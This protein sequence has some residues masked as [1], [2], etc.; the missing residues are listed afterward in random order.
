ML[1]YWQLTRGNCQLSPHARIG[2]RFT[3]PHPLGVVIGIG[4][5]IGNDVSIWQQVTLGNDGTV[6]S[7]PTVEDGVRIYAGSVVIGRIRLG[8][9]ALSCTVPGQQGRSPLERSRS[10]HPHAS[11]AIPHSPF[12]SCR[13]NKGVLLMSNAQNETPSANLWLANSKSICGILLRLQRQVECSSRIQLPK[14]SDDHRYFRCLFTNNCGRLS[15][16]V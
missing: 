12:Q 1:S 15:S 6:E 7:Y 16:G 13:T 8:G 10:G 11:I 9:T 2:E 5:H 14:H 3:L 4:C